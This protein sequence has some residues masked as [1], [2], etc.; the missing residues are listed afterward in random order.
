MAATFHTSHIE[1]HTPT[2]GSVK[3]MLRGVALD[4]RKL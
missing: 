4:R 3:G 2:C 1:L